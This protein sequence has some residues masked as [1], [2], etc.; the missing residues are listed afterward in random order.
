MQKPIDK[1][2]HRTTEDA[3]RPYGNT[4]SYTPASDL[5]AAPF[6]PAAENYSPPATE[7]RTPS[8]DVGGC[9][10]DALE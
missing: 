7:P 9:T 8:F 1:T 3:R 4:S 6:V 5:S 10:F 2:K